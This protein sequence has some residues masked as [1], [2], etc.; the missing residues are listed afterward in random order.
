MSKRWWHPL[1][2]VGIVA[3]VIGVVA[4]AARS[5]IRRELPERTVI[6]AEDRDGTLLAVDRILSQRWQEAGITPAA[7]A[8]DL[9]VLRRLSLALHGSIPSLEEI[10]LFEADTQPR[11]LDRWTERLLA[12]RRFADYFA[13]RLSRAFVGAEDGQFIVFRRDRFNAWLSDQLHDSQPYDQIVREIISEQGLWTGKPATNFIT[14]AVADEVIDRN[15]LA[16]RTVRA[17]LGQ[18][19]DCAQCHNHPFADWKQAQF[20][21]L[22]ACFGEVQVSAVG[23]EDNPTLTYEVKDNMMQA[24]RKVAPAVPFKSEWMPAEGTRR[25]RLAAWVTHPD[26]RRFERATVNRVWGLLFGRPW[27][28]P[29][30]DL[31][32]PE[33]YSETDLLDVLGKDFREHHYDL[34]RLIGLITAT[35]AYRLSSEHEAWETGELAEAVDQNWAAFPM[36]RLRPEQI[37]GSMLQAS[38]IKTADRNQHLLFRTIRLF[39]EID[40]VKEYGDLGD[41]EFKDR[42]GTIPQALLRMNGRFSQETLKAEIFNASGRISAMAPGADRCLETCFLVCLSRRPTAEELSELRS[43]LEQADKNQRAEVV[44]DLFWALFNSPEF[45]WNH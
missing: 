17:F 19:I 42:A 9:T 23:I 15:E 8:E 45:S 5:P 37:I 27:M 20:E 35:Q 33:S 18:R 32:N 13:A 4:V 29:V 12:D 24:A 10:R 22:A 36:S 40:F 26:N 38:S 28:A 30:D 39:R 7:A 16:G 1:L 3:G 31:P 25:Q 6:S 11:R 44:E 21:G 43:A 34:K 14:A 41:D 2:P